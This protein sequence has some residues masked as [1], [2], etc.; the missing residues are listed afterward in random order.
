MLGGTAK[1]PHGYTSC[2]ITPH[3]MRWNASA[4]AHRQQRIAAALG[5][6]AGNAADLVAAFIAALGLPRTLRDVGVGQDQLPAI[7]A[8][9]RGDIW[10]RTNPRPMHSAEDVLEIL[11]AAF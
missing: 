2:I 4:N 1:V 8:H 5:D 7:A 10:G 11:R 6:P 3:V 9:A